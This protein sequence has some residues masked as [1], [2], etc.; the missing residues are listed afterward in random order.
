MLAR[1]FLTVPGFLFAWLVCVAGTPIWLPVCALIDLVRRR[2]VTL[3]CGAFLTAYFTCEAIGLAASAL[4]WAWGIVARPDRERWFAVHFRLQDGWGSMVFGAIVRLFGLRLDVKSE[5]DLAR[6]PYLLL[7]RHASSADT[8]LASALVCR[9]H[10]IHLR[11]VLKREILWDPCIDVVG[12][13]LPHVFIDR[14]SDDSAREIE[15]VATAARDLGPRDGLL[16]YPEGT[17]FSLAKQARIRKRLRRGG[18]AEAIA[19]AESL[20]SVLP[21]R[22]GGVLGALAAAPHVDVVICSHAGFE[23]TASIGQIWRGALVGRTVRVRFRRVR[24]ADIPEG[25]EDAFRWLRDEWRQVDAWVSRQ[26]A[27]RTTVRA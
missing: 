26:S 9:P 21:P 11:Y 15:R 25:R 23:G 13:R 3:R 12:N 14:A 18:D 24:R 1:R 17:R 22:P 4:L 6:G 5:A 27:S 20:Q 10:G 19:Q 2:V 8:L 16:I 7:V